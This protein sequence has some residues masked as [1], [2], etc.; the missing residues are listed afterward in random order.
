LGSTTR[1]TTVAPDNVGEFCGLQAI[2]CRAS[3]VLVQPLGSR[4]FPGRND[5]IRVPGGVPKSSVDSE[6]SGGPGEPVVLA[7][8]TSLEC[9]TGEL[10]GA[11]WT[12]ESP[13]TRLSPVPAIRRCTA[14]A[15]C[16][17][18]A[19]AAGSRSFKSQWL[20]RA[21]VIR[22]ESRWTRMSPGALAL[23]GAP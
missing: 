11:R 2:A 17:Q 23:A 8:P 15:G 6:E 13:W 12:P 21:D 22:E 14:V 10:R 5:D 16:E 9:V 7:G 18:P 3:W 19:A 20:R 1:L 4:G